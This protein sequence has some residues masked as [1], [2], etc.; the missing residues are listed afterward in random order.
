MKKRKENIVII[1]FSVII[2]LLL[3]LGIFS[4]ENK[5]EKNVGEQQS[6]DVFPY[7]DES[8]KSES[9]TDFSEI[10]DEPETETEVTPEKKISVDEKNED[11][12][13][14]TDEKEIESKSE[15]TISEYCLII[16]GDSR[17]CS[18]FNSVNKFEE[19]TLI[20]DNRVAPDQGWALLDNQ[21]LKLAICEYGG[22]NLA[23]GAYDKG[24]AWAEEVMNAQWVTEST[25]FCIFNIFGLGD[26]NTGFFPDS[27]GYYN[28]RGEKFAKQYQDQCVYYQCTVGPIDENG[29]MGQAGVWTNQMIKDFN[30]KFMKTKNV[31]LYDLN[32]FLEKNEYGCV[33]SESDPTGVHYQID[34]DR[35][36]L[37][38]FVDIA[39]HVG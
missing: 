32:S 35:K 15:E 23:N 39:L 8:K 4:L 20:E 6:T 19:W 16:I 7:S 29:T 11:K 36:I 9:T 21:E 17:A 13:D 34:T 24:L 30:K 38:E 12:T 28:D 31:K 2:L 37:D 33:I 5:K 27:D 18:L 10:E 3:L 25:K 26:V 22:G 14:E 1:V